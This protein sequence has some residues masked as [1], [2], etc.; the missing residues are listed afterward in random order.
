MLSFNFNKGGSDQ[1]DWVEKYG[2]VYKYYGLLNEPRLSILD[3]K[4]L[5]QMLVSEVYTNFNKKKVPLGMLAKVFGK[6]IAMVEGET[7]KKHR[8]MMNPIFSH[9]SVKV[10]KNK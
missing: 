6:G 4:I 5:Q 2:H 7:H 8:K 9:N 10:I 3:G 1:A